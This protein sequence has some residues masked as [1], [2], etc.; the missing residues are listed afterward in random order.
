MFLSE[1]YSLVDLWWLPQEL[2][3]LPILE[4]SSIKKKHIP[5]KFVLHPDIV[6]GLVPGIM[7]LYIFQ[8]LPLNSSRLSGTD[9]F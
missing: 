8:F 5:L 9:D 7:F 1:I 4:H 2:L 6:L 3:D